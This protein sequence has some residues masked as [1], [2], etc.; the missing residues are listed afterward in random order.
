MEISIPRP[1]PPRS[2]H[3]SPTRSLR[4]LPVPAEESTT[5]RTS[6]LRA[7]FDVRP[8]WG[9]F[10]GGPCCASHFPSIATKHARTCAM[11]VSNEAKWDVVIVGAGV[12]GASLATQLGRDGRSVLVLERDLSEPDRIIGELLQ[13]G[14]FQKLQELGL[15]ECVEGIDA[16]EVHGY[17]IFRDGEQ[18]V[19]PYPEAYVAEKDG[20]AHV[21]GRSFHHGRFIMKL[22]QAA[23]A[24]PNVELKQGTV[25]KLLAEDGSEWVDHETKPQRVIGVCYTDAQGKKCTARADL[26]I[27]CDGMYSKFRKN[28]SK[29]EIDHPS[30]FVGLILENCKLPQPNHGHVI[31]AD[32]SP[33]LFYPIS[34][35]ETRV[36]VDIAGER[37]PSTQTG[38][39]AKYMKESVAPQVPEVLRQPFLDAVEK[40]GF[41]SMRNTILP[42]KPLHC[43]GALLL[44]DAFNMRHPLTG[45]GMTVAL[46]DITTLANMLRP[47]PDFAD[48]EAS[49]RTTKAFYHKI[50][51]I[52]ATIN[53]LANALYR[54]FCG[55]SGNKAHDEMREACFHYL[56]QGGVYSEGPISLLSGLNPQ[57]VV[58]VMHFFLVAFFGVK[59]VVSHYGLAGLWLGSQ[60]IACATAIIYPIIKSEGLLHFM[61]AC[62]SA[63]RPPHSK[64]DL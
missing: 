18:C 10:P 63:P 45:G 59:R 43:P 39:M 26:S 56:K 35:T 48:L 41:R 7:W 19:I 40:G 46:S 30:F 34:S 15:E 60:V 31:L 22:R 6:P 28:L 57:P 1:G 51:P 53:T 62:A 36:L 13:P 20:Y 16:Q 24:V 2:R 3:V 27:V 37:I 8:W 50:R 54:V 38:D 49:S 55:G 42:G 32:P 44:G 21:A 12:A 33:V 47:L 14:G 58:L 23:A 25:N 52:A 64:K 9:V 5:H 17:C 4:D 61:R 29:P 11:T